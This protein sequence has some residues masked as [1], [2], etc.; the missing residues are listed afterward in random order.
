MMGFLAYPCKN[1]IIPAKCPLNTFYSAALIALLPW[2][3]FKKKR[4]AHF[5]SIARDV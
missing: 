4:N 3:E 1:K 5:T 2:E